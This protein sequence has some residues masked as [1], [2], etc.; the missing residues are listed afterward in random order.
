MPR[1]THPALPFDIAVSQSSKTGKKLWGTLNGKGCSCSIA[2]RGQ[3]CPHVKQKPVSLNTKWGEFCGIANASF[4]L[5]GE[6]PRDLKSFGESLRKSSIKDALLSLSKSASRSAANPE[7]P[8]DTQFVVTTQTWNTLS[9]GLSQRV[10]TLLMG[11]TQCGKTEIVRWWGKQANRP[12]FHFNVGSWF[13][14][15][16]QLV[17]NVHYTP[18]IGTVFRESDFVKA[19]QT[20]DAVVLLDEL[21]RAD[22]HVQNALMNCLDGVRELRLD[23]H[24]DCPVIQFAEGVSFAAAANT[25]SDYKGTQVMDAAVL[26]R[27]PV[28]IQMEYMD[29]D[30]ETKFLLRR[31]CSG[32]VCPIEVG[33]LTKFAEA[34]RKAKASGEVKANFS[35]A[36]V[37][38]I[39]EY[40]AVTESSFEDAMDVMILPAAAASRDVDK[41]RAIFVGQ[42]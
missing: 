7:K 33:E 10:N 16:S 39:A 15:S 36:R 3:S 11:P 28:V 26:E 5:S 37:I 25:G 29:K 20:P 18:E 1:Y 21:T 17:G 30:A 22:Y 27:F 34:I 19:V 8:D 23:G 12:V 42:K 38:Q 4:G 41:F 14:P 40:M 9:Y 2:A 32:S 31:D 24:P 6:Y 13:N 35:T